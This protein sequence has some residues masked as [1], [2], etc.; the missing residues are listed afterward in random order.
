MTKVH[1]TALCQFA[2]RVAVTR[3]N[4]TSS[5]RESVIIYRSRETVNWNEVNK[6]HKRRFY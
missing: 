1:R 4:R 5:V 6:R 2:R 3:V